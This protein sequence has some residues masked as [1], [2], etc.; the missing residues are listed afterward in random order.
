MINKDK[1]EYFR[2]RLESTWNFYVEFLEKIDQESLK[3]YEAIVDSNANRDQEQYLEYFKEVDVH[4]RVT[5]YSS[6]LITFCSLAEY[7]LKEITKEIVPE[8]ENEI[9]KE[10][11]DWL[12]KNLKLIKRIEKN[13]DIDENN[14][15]LF[16]C[17]IK[18]RNCIVHDGGVVSN[19]KHREQLET[20]IN[21]VIQYGKQSNL[22][23]LELT[24]DGHLLLGSDLV[25]D[26][27]IKSEDV[28]GKILKVV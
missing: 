22:L 17:Y 12:V 16:S 25:G 2:R 28:L 24:E 10:Q 15:R 7:F 27:V 3:I 23:L 20:A 9:K 1:L 5:L 6:M 26:V 4:Y 11:G 18:V 13:L 19:S 8:Y 14:I 21:E